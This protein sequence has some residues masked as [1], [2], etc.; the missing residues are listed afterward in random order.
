MDSKKHTAINA[1]RN[2]SPVQQTRATCHLYNEPKSLTSSMTASALRRLDGTRGV[3]T[4]TGACFPAFPA[5]V[6]MVGTMPNSLNR[7][8]SLAGGD[9]EACAVGGGRELDSGTNGVGPEG[10]AAGAVPTRL[11][12]ADAECRLPN[13]PPLLPEVDENDEDCVAEDG[14][15]VGTAGDRRSI[16]GRSTA[17][18]RAERHNKTGQRGR[19]GR[20]G[21]RDQQVRGNGASR[22]E[23]VVSGT[24]VGFKQVHFRVD[25]ATEYLAQH[26]AP[27]VH[28]L[29]WKQLQL[30]TVSPTA[31]VSRA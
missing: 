10:A 3:G 22:Q 12:S 30:W 15:L 11:G 14:A 31:L 5:V 9:A 23:F 21:T 26:G 27:Q 19:D 16:A 1:K 13:P 20:G 8:I 24:D 18:Q 29:R 7:S 4:A 2:T 17:A 6:L 28:G 25:V